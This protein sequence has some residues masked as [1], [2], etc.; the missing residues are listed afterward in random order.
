M[1][2]MTIQGSRMR[3][4]ARGQLPRF[5]CSWC[6][7]SWPTFFGDSVTKR[8][9]RYP[10]MKWLLR[11]KSTNLGELKRIAI[12]KSPKV[13]KA[14]G[15][16]NNSDKGRRLKI[17]STHKHLTGESKIRRT[18]ISTYRLNSLIHQRVD[19]LQVSIKTSATVKWIVRAQ[20]STKLL[21]RAM[22]AKRTSQITHRLSMPPCWDKS[23]LNKTFANSRR[24][25]RMRISIEI[26]LA[27][28]QTTSAWHIAR[29]KQLCSVWCA[30]RTWRAAWTIVFLAFYT[31]QAS[32]RRTKEML[33]LLDNH[34]ML[35]LNNETTAVWEW[36]RSNR[37]P[38]CPIR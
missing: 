11:Q 30:H 1:E 20:S 14:A 15:F 34:R 25:M 36:A 23:R 7:W 35:I 33:L 26:E 28:T 19:N 4:S 2:Q 24:Q 22:T 12:R 3:S 32:W 10:N 13:F 16:F 8:M 38:W 37:S 29:M 5:C 17:P 27:Q 9:K 31:N 18:P 6:N 21:I